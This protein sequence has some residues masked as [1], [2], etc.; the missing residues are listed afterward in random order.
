MNAPAVETAGYEVKVALR[1][2]IIE[3]ALVA[4][5]RLARLSLRIY[6]QATWRNGRWML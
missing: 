5:G 6:S 1:R 4:L 3:L 2:L